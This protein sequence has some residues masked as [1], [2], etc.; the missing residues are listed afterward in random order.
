MIRVILES[1]LGSRVDG[2]RASPEEFKR[3][4]EYALEC[5]RDSLA[6]G[7]APFASHVLYPLVLN[8]ATPAERKQGMQAGFAW[9]DC[10]ELVAVYVDFGITPG[11]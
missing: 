4:Q 5:M 1:P 8:D 11:V 3:N 9:G 6:R 7:E 2:T 10:A